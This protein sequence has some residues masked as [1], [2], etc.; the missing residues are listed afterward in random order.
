[1]YNNFQVHFSRELPALLLYFPVYN[2]A[3]T[4]EVQG[5]QIGPIYQPNDRFVTI[6]DWFLLARGGGSETTELGDIGVIDITPDED[7]ML[8]NGIISPIVI[9]PFQN[10]YSEGV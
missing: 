2:Y 9:K 1:M 8:P 5:I 7:Q 10:T 6:G 4:D 3:V